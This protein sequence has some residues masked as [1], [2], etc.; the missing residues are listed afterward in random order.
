MSDSFLECT[1]TAQVTMIGPVVLFHLINQL[2][3]NRSHGC[4][5]VNQVIDSLPPAIVLVGRSGRRV[6][7]PKRPSIGN[8]FGTLRP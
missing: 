8:A 7:V 6:A 5:A 3:V 4:D 1:Q 2:I